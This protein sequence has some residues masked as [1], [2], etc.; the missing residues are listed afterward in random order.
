[1][2]NILSKLFH[3]IAWV[4]LLVFLG[5]GEAYATDLSGISENIVKSVERLP[6]L[7]TGAAYLLGLV[8]G[9]WGIFKL[10]EH[11]DNPV[12]APLRH[13]ITRFLA[14]GALFAL[15]I[16]YNAMVQ[17]VGAGNA[18]LDLNAGFLASASGVIG[19]ILTFAPL[20][21]VNQILRNIID[22]LQDVPGLITAAGYLL[23]LVLGVSG[24]LKLKEHV[25]NPDQVPL[26]EGVIRF[27]IG[28]ALFSLP[29]IYVAM[30]ESIN[31]AGGVLDYLAGAAGALGITT[32]TEDPFSGGCVLGIFGSGVGSVICNLFLHT[33]AFPAF[34]MAFSYLSGLVLGFWGILKLKDHVLNPQQTSVW[35]P[36]SRFIAGGALF[37]LPTVMA[38]AYNTVASVLLPHFNRG[39]NE[40]AVGAGDGLDVKLTAFMTDIFAPMTIIINWFGIVAGIILIII[41]I[42]RLMK[43]AQEGA[44]GPGG[45]GTIMTFIAG[46]A[47][48]SFSPMITA[49]STSFFGTDGT[50]TLTN[51]EMAYT[52]GMDPAA[53]QHVHNVISAVIRFMIVL[54]MVSFARGIFIVRGVAE[55]NQQASMMAGVTHLLGGALAINLGPVMNAV[56][57]TLGLTAYGVNF[58]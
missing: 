47:L 51:A 13:A 4:S 3:S 28:G 29:A 49:F 20:Q 17:T 16:I 31:S 53:V 8:F 27:L 45:I 19:S 48:L 58:K 12:Q 6:A 2:I 10:K 26:R 21:D 57:S 24:I 7:I 15:P 30:Y 42:M 9:V 40:K 54:G 38:A 34:L 22:S 11:V 35:E 36:V 1:M 46:G 50:V 52:T 39:F 14:G 37:A 18:N 56:Q 25:D 33:G 55:G 44:R 5:V 23:G 43:S 41:G 32:S